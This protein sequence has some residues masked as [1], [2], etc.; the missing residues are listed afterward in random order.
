MA[1]LSIALLYEQKRAFDKHQTK[2]L[3][4]L[5]WFNYTMQTAIVLY[6]G[7]ASFIYE[8]NEKFKIVRAWLFFIQW[9]LVAFFLVCATDC[10]AKFAMI[11]K[12]HTKNISGLAWFAWYFVYLTLVIYPI[13]AAEPTWGTVIAV[14]V[15]VCRA[16]SVTAILVLFSAFLIVEFIRLESFLRTTA[17]KQKYPSYRNLD[18]DD[19]DDYVDR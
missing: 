6:Y 17:P 8:N 3:T 13:N 12:Q 11:D 18:D 5:K 10:R 9:T 4:C 2:T 14:Y 15:Y 1:I 16:L 19:S 7:V